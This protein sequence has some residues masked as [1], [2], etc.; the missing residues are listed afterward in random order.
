MSC[1]DHND[2]PHY[3]YHFTA[4]AP[5]TLFLKHSQR[6]LVQCIFQLQMLSWTSVR[7]AGNS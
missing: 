2:D 3:H 7:G 5:N 4:L 1:N 6:L